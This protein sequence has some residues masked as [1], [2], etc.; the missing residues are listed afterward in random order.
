M[1]K[2]TKF[3]KK[4]ALAGLTAI[5]M[6]SVAQAAPVLLFDDYVYANDV[7]GTAL[8]GL[9]L[10]VTRVSNDTD[11]NAAITGSYGLVVVQFDNTSHSI[12]L[13]DYLA[14]GGKLI[15]GNW[16]ST[17][18]ATLGV[19]QGNSNVNNLDITTAAL[20]NG[21]SSATQ[22]LVNPTYGVYSHELSGGTSLASLG[23]QSGIVSTFGGNVLVNGFLGETL[24]ATADEVRLYQNEVGL[25]NGAPSD[26]PEPSTYATM[27]LGLALLAALT[28]KKGA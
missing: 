2:F 17:D 7:W 27:G 11:F 28:R 12:N 18:D 15:Y 3:A 26:V 13:T 20:S 23:G 16:L 8:S 6:T 5:T 25:L 22:T 10:S 1:M 14:S 9:G 19:M 21:L 4:M 24:A